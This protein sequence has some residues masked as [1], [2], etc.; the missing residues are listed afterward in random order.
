MFRVLVLLSPL[1][2]LPAPGVGQDPPTATCQA[3]PGA[4]RL[5]HVV[6]VVRDLDSARARLTRLGFR[7]KAGRRHANN[8]RNFHVKFLD[9][10]ALEV[11]TVTGA[12]LDR[13]AEDYAD[14]LAAGE[15]GAYVALRSS[16]LDS[17]AAAAE[18]AG[19]AGRPSAIGSW[20]F[21][22]F[23]PYS[24][25]GGVF[26]GDGWSGVPDPDSMVRHPNRAESLRQAWVE[27]GPALEAMLRDVG[28]APCD[29]V[30]LPDGRSGLSWALGTGS[31]VVVPIRSNPPRPRPVGAL[32]GTR[33]R[34]FRPPA[35]SLGLPEFW[36]VFQARDARRH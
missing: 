18:R 2:V 34:A 14:L 1:L 24:D 35:P 32:L 20:R 5:D 21:L 29:S 4:P 19:L 11:M 13:A 28:A 23:E 6:V 16:Q 15:G 9:G 3:R 25:A 33:S 31:L 12:P 8:L 7:Y 30:L 10:T 27:G 22:S 17:I 26:F 36:V